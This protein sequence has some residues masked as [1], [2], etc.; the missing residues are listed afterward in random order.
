MQ[1]SHYPESILYIYIFFNWICLQSRKWKKKKYYPYESNSWKIYTENTLLLFKVIYTVYFS[2]RN[3]LGGKKEIIVFSFTQPFSAPGSKIRYFPLKRGVCALN[4]FIKA[5]LWHETHKVCFST[6][7]STNSC[8]GWRSPHSHP[9]SP[10]TPACFV[11]NKADF[12]T[13]SDSLASK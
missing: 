11:C 4:S 12:D 8:L 3:F 7:G 5:H 6:E 13:A 2:K 9:L 1:F 10:L